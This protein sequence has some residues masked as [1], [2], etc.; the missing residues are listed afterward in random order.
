MQQE[1]NNQQQMQM[2]M[3][4]N[5]QFNPN[6]QVIYPIHNVVFMMLRLRS[7]SHLKHHL[8]MQKLV[9]FSRFYINKKMLLQYIRK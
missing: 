5:G 7:N 9:T 1:Q 2:Q 4:M 3:N 6:M 8:W